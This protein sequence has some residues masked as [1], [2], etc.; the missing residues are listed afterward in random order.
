MSFLGTE[1]KLFQEKVQ[2]PQHCIQGNYNLTPVYLSGFTAY[3]QPIDINICS[4]LQY[5]KLA[6]FSNGSHSPVDLTLEVMRLN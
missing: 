1:I 4:H 6:T 3:N 2:I 5:P